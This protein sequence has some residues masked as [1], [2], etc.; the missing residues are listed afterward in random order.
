MSADTTMLIVPARSAKVSCEF[1]SVM[2]WYRSILESRFET[3]CQAMAE[4]YLPVIP[5]ISWQAGSS[6]AQLTCSYSY[7][8]TITSTP[9]SPKEY[10][11]SIAPSEM[12]S[13]ASLRSSVY[14]PMHMK[15]LQQ[16]SEHYSKSLQYQS[17]Q[18]YE[19][20]KFSNLQNVHLS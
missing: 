5:F 6:D 12:H 8:T 11:V 18:E 7:A 14:T 10:L 20:M 17:L 16:Q 4:P 1:I 3:V 15:N 2:K 9:C 19:C 13:M